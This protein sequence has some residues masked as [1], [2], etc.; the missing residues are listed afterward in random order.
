MQLLFIECLLC[1][2]PCNVPSEPFAHITVLRPHTSLEECGGLMTP[3][4]KWENGKVQRGP[5]TQVSKWQGWDP[6]LQL[7]ALS[8]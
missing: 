6:I 2:R 4:Y 7:L 8:S 1:A 3:F 5:V